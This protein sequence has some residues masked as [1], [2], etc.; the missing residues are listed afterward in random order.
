MINQESQAKKPLLS[1]H[2]LS[3]VEE[4]QQLE[5]TTGGVNPMEIG[6]RATNLIAKGK[7]TASEARLPMDYGRVV[8]FRKVDWGLD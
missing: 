3:N 5:A 1:Q 2:S 4:E 6:N 8:K 7:R